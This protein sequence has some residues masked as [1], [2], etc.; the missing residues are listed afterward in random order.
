MIAVLNLL[1]WSAAVP[2]LIVQTYLILELLIGLLPVRQGRARSDMSGSH[3]AFLIP[4]HNEGTVIKETVLDLQTKAQN[5]RIIVIA[6]NCTDDTAHQARVEGV[7]VIERFDSEN[8]G[9]GFALDFGREYLKKSPPDFVMIVDADCSV[10]TDFTAEMVSAICTHETPAQAS[11]LFK[12][13]L[14]LSPTVQVSNFAMLVKNLFRMRGLARLG[15]TVALL[16]TGMGFP[17]ATFQSLKLATGDATEDIKMTIDLVSLGS[18]VFFAENAQ[19]FSNAETDSDTVT[20]RQRWEHGFLRHS[21][22]YGIPNLL[23]GL[24]RL[25]RGQ[26]AL[27][28]HLLVPP[29]ALLLVAS[30]AVIVMLGL[31]T[32]LGASFWPALISSMSFAVL[33]VLLAA[34]YLVK[35]RQ[36]L[37][38]AAVLRAPAYLFWKLPIYLNFI[39]R[40]QKSWDE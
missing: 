36:Y 2:F 38:G 14:T 19:V 17:W 25:S 12:P 9:K 33:I 15:G 24:A 29:I 4:A 37:S 28:F 21:I 32:F 18:R 6:D 11:N 39:R 35:G 20:Q 8:R 30:T 3:V 40:R 27:A 5:S 7:E 31:A 1:L 13:D 16:G 23:R 26:I 22:N 34:A 10:S